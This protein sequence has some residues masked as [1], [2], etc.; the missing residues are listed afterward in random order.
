MKKIPILILLSLLLLSSCSSLKQDELTVSVSGNATVSL[1]ADIADFSITVAE[2]RETT[3][4]AQSAVNEKMDAIYRI[5]SSYGITEEDLVTNSVS[6]S[7]EYVWREDGQELVGQ[8]ARATLGVTLRDIQLL[9]SL[10]DSLS[11][12]SGISLSSIT[13]DA[14][15]KS[16]A[17]SEARRLAMADALS[18]AEVYADS[19]GLVVDKAISITE[20]SYYANVDRLEDERVEMATAALEDSVGGGA[21]YAADL[22]V[23]AEVAVTYSMISGR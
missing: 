2:I 15:D 22:S 18:R 7:P 21:Y 8:R 5:L 9:S 13:L 23:Y 16:G 12:V 19:A 4:E 3:G 1:S 17:I 11:E 14:S 10:I 20:S 6:L